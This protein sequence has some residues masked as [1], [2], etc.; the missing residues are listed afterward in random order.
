MTFLQALRSCHH[1]AV[2]NPKHLK[3]TKAIGAHS[4]FSGRRLGF[5]PSRHLSFDQHDEKREISEYAH[6]Q[7]NLLAASLV[8]NDATSHISVF[9]SRNI[10]HDTSPNHGTYRQLRDDTPSSLTRSFPSSISFAQIERKKPI[11]TN[12][13]IRSITSVA[14]LVPEMAKNITI[15]GGSG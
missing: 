5:L 12:Q 4:K 1:R 15:W 9:K 3:L 7:D 13:T 6:H 14:E 8:S 10:S 2:R 11:N